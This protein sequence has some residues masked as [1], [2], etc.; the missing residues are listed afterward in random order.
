MLRFILGLVSAIF[1]HSQAHV[2]TLAVDR[3]ISYWGMPD[4]GEIRHIPA[5]RQ[6]QVTCLDLSQDGRF[7]ATGTDGSVVRV[8]RYREGD[9]VRLGMARCGPITA[10]KFGPNGHRILAATE[11]GATVVWNMD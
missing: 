5:D 11:F 7:I 3:Q 10:V 6:G 9:V 4:G 2:L 8:M 1:H